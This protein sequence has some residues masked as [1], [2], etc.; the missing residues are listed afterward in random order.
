MTQHWLASEQR[1][2]TQAAKFSFPVA[3]LSELLQRLPRAKKKEEKTKNRCSKLWVGEGPSL[4]PRCAA[5]ALALQKRAR[6]PVAG[7]V[8]A[9]GQ[10]LLPAAPPVPAAAHLARPRRRPLLRR[11]AHLQRIQHRT[12]QARKIIFLATAFATLTFFFVDFL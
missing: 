10:P 11:L 7:D 1:S 3:W 6:H 8:A 9:R 4:P 2:T 5:A 12:S